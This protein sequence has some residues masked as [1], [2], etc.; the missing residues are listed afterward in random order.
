MKRSMGWA[1]K[2]WSV[3]SSLTHKKAEP[4]EEKLKT[5]QFAGRIPNV[6]YLEIVES[7]SGIEIYRGEGKFWVK[8]QAVSSLIKATISARAVANNA[9]WIIRGRQS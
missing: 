1:W 9:K 7:H 8:G 3:F 2:V 4:Y 6:P 5:L